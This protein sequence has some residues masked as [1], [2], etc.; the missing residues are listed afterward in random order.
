MWIGSEA[1]QG[2]GKIQTLL[3]PRPGK[4]SLDRLA[5]AMR[6]LAGVFRRGRRPR[7]SPVSQIVGLSRLGYEASTG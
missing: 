3:P 2:L 6:G 5:W 7:P 1:E 4:G